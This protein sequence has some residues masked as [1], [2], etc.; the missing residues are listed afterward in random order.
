MSLRFISRPLLNQVRL[1]MPKLCLIGATFFLSNQTFAELTQA[2]MS[3]L[4]ESIR[5]EQEMPGLRAAVMFPDGR[6]LQAAVGLADVETNLVLDND[7][8]MPGGSTGKTFVAALAMLLV[9]DGTLSLDDHAS[10]WLSDRSWFKKLP[11]KDTMLVR[12]LL[13]HS[14]GLEDYSNTMRYMTWMF[15]R[16]IRRGG[17]TFTREELIELVSN[18]EPLFPAGT[19]YAYTD[20]GYIVLGMLIETAAGRPYYE[21]VNKRI[22]Q[23]QKLD[24]V[25]PQDA[26]VLSDITPGYS[27][28]ARNLRKDGTMKFDPT[29]EWTGGGLV[30]N[31][32]MLVRF[33]NAL[34]QGEVTSP[35]S[36]KIMKTSGWQ[37]PDTPDRHYGFGLFVTHHAQVVE[38][39][40]LWPGYRS[41]VRHY[42]DDQVTIAVQTNRDGVDLEAVV[43]QVKQLIP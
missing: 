16:A 18:R 39:G 8:G 24:Q 34:A 28:G 26:S 20:S 25:R 5:V 12:H 10:K 21:L 19:G 17:I 40:G 7:V 43:D 35:E 41:H 38:H 22:L 2:S 1:S 30:T 29:I 14:A 33:Y 31:P 23:P 3:D 42:L 37:N 36:F 27:R 9:E 32:T 13:S 15:W 4:L 6:E 11:N